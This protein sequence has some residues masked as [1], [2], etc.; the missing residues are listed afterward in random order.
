MSA[1]IALAALRYLIFEPN[2]PETYS[3]NDLEFAEA[4]VDLLRARHPLLDA[5][6]PDLSAF[7]AA[8]G[9]LI[10][11]HGWSDEH[12]SPRTTIAYHEA[13]QQ[14]MGG[15]DQVAEFER[16][17]LLP[18][19]QHC[20][21]GDGMAAIDLVTP[22][23]QW[24]EQDSAPHQVLTSSEQEQPPW[25]PAAPVH[26]TRP[27]FPYPSLAKYSGQGDANDAANF[28]EGAPLY[29]APTAAW[30][31]QDFFDPYMPRTG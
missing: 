14:Q 12:I 22:L 10:M 1:F 16:L 6:S 7:K 13:L 26:R 29:T 17:Y 28:V 27:V 30:A 18:G 19:V 31:G 8:G 23:L 4:T 5:T 20:G 25:M 21:R 9:K 24:V 2:P 11:W 15:S 3:L